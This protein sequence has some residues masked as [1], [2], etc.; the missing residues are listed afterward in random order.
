M[1]RMVLAVL[2]GAGLMGCASEPVQL[3]QNRSYILEWIGERPLMDY[4]HLTI[5]LG[6]VRAVYPGRRPVEFRQDW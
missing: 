5:T 1:K 4:S 6:E 2:I 3:Q